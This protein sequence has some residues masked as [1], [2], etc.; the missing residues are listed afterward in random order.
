MRRSAKRTVVGTGNSRSGRLAAGRS[1]HGLECLIGIRRAARL[2]VPK[3]FGSLAG[4]FSLAARLT[5]SGYGGHAPLSIPLVPASPRRAK[6]RLG[7]SAALPHSVEHH[8]A[9]PQLR[10]EPG[11][12]RR[13]AFPGRPRSMLAASAP[14]SL[15]QGVGARLAGRSF[16]EV[17]AVGRA[18]L[19]LSRD[20]GKPGS[21]ASGSAGASPSRPC[22]FTNWPA[23]GVGVG[24]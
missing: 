3:D 5:T 10:H 6:Q 16:W 2:R 20:F 18:K 11:L 9:L 21:R 4:Q 23:V 8:I 17:C 13:T 14:S 7:H 19:L 15:N 12:P 24:C 1:R 22:R